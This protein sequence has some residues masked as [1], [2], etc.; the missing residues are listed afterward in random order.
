M[1]KSGSNLK[2]H[3][4]DQ[5]LVDYILIVRNK[6]KDLQGA[7]ERNA[8]RHFGADKLKGLDNKEIFNLM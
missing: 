4:S 3:L 7:I 5:D 8:I 6:V 1:Q 2:P